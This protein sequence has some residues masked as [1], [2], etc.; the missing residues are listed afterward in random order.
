MQVVSY[1]TVHA[2]KGLNIVAKVQEYFNTTNDTIS[3]AATKLSLTYQQVAWALAYNASPKE[4][5]FVALPESD[6]DI[7]VAMAANAMLGL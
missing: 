2:W 1:T 3:N 6:A 5:Q 7:P 4:Y